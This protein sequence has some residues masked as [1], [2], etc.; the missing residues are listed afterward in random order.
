MRFLA[1]SLRYISIVVLVVLLAGIAL[2]FSGK[3]LIAQVLPS[4]AILIAINALFEGMYRFFR[5]LRIT[6]EK[7]QSNWER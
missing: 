7:E 5:G 4:L 1:R 3:L 2:N 6:G